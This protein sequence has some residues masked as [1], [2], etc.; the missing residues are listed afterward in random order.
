MTRRIAPSLALLVL[1]VGLAPPASAQDTGVVAQ[2]YDA[3]AHGALDAASCG[4]EL[5]RGALDG[6]G[7]STT[8]V[9]FLE[10]NYNALVERPAEGVLFGPTAGTVVS[11]A[12]QVY[13]PGLDRVIV[14]GDDSYTYAKC[15]AAHYT[16]WAARTY[17]W[18]QP[19]VDCYWVHSDC[20]IDNLDCNALMIDALFD[21]FDWLLFGGPMPPGPSPC[22]PPAGVYCVCLPPSNPHPFP[23]VPTAEEVIG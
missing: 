6:S 17:V 20:G 2:S 10:T 22:A 1:L 5:A 18:Y 13:G 9:N 7:Q 8:P 3:L 14:F 15:T 12:D 23:T 19:T 11:G 4:W 16:T 21:L